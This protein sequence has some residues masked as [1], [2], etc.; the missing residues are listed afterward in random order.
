MSHPEF[1]LWDFPTRLF[2][3]SLALAVTAASISGQL[4]GGLMTWHGRIGLAV[5]GLV[6]FRLAWGLVGSTYARF[7]QFFPTRQG[8]KAYLSG[9]WRGEGHNPLGALSVLGILG[10]LAV[11]V[12]TGLF[13][14][15]D[16]AFR[17][18]L[19]DLAGKTLSNRL[20]AIHHLLSKL[21][22]LLVALHLGAIAFYASARKQNLVKPMLT[23]R[24]EGV[25]ESAR[26]GGLAA[27][28]VALVLAAMAVFGASGK[29]MPAPPPPP[30]AAA[31]PDF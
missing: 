18:P 9:Q 12:A 17:G 7:A 23:G 16:I 6:V 15:D 28:A 3:W 19:Y 22:Y 10:L 4:G 26:G 29:W 8:I 25:G 1:R 21:V 5:V 13:S 30:P 2:H 24:K 27:L 31:T 11:Q 20:T 14:N